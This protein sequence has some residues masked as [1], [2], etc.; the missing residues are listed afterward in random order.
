[1]SGV[2]LAGGFDLPFKEQSDFFRKKLNVQTSAWDD[3]WQAEHDRAFMVAGAAKADL[4]N[5]LRKAVDKAIATG[6]S[7]ETFRKDFKK[8]VAD[9]GWTGWTGE[10]SKAG[11][12]WRTR[13]IY[14]TNLRSSYAAGRWAQLNDPS[15]K[16][17]MPFWRYVHNDSVL[18][19]RPLHKQWGQ[20]RLT[21]PADHVFWKTHF[22]PNGW[23][24]RCR[25]VAAPGPQE[26]D[27]T[28]PPVGWDTIDEKTGV[29]AGIDKGWAYA[30]GEAA[31]TRTQRLA[32]AKAAT[33]PEPLAT[34]FND[35]VL[36]NVK[37][38]F[39]EAKSAKEASAAAVKMGLVDF[40]DYSG[41]A[42]EVANAFNRSLF[43]HLEEFPALRKNQKFVG[44][45]QAQFAAWRSIEIQRVTSQL[46]AL[47]PDSS[48]DFEAIAKKIVKAKKVPGNAYAQS[49]S[50][51][52]VSGISV[53]KAHGKDADALKA[54]LAKDVASGFHPIGCAEIRSVVDHE[55]AHQ[56]DD[57]LDLH[58][59]AEVLSV[60]KE[61]LA[62]G[63]KNEVS[64]YAG[65]NVREFIAECWAESCNA[66]EPR[67]FAQRIE[68]IVRERYSR[69]F[70]SAE[71]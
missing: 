1:M 55:L 68:R 60:Y 2:S 64:I 33:L 54:S 27:A 65:K 14:E 25:V 44:S 36:K 13:V 45:S 41:V 26:G 61:A 35:D 43:D 34:A 42:V 59:D 71:S 50:Q 38:V 31:F 46:R 37:R 16:K 39:V 62:A 21:L 3:I 52:D 12:A 19:P 58:V 23:G 24:C 20:V 47:N 40:A 10:G 8:I 32:R 56:L 67:A 5:D 6:T 69:R 29:P 57:L 30:P 70:G 48:V 28:E 7:L 49:W 4:L 11:E 15:F 53:N 18:S 17:L 51:R 66:A 9:N 63:I 22:P